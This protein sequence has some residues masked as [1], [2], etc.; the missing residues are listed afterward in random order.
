MILADGN[1]LIAKSWDAHSDNARAEKFF[2][3]NPKV[4]TCPITE[5]NLVRVLMQRGLSGSEAD[6]V[7]HNF[8]SKHRS[9][10]IP[11]DISATEIKGQC[12][13]H[14]QTT[15]AYLAK[16]AKKHR[17]KVATFDGAFARQF[18]DLVDLL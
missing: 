11:C 10:L 18:P 3:D 4:V 7:L 8:V 16:L 9:R 6:K 14:R 5:L 13:G 2:A 1:L 12:D 17:L 15:D